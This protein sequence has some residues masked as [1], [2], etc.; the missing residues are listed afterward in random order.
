MAEHRGDI[1]DIAVVGPVFQELQGVL[2]KMPWCSLL[3]VAT[4][5]PPHWLEVEDEWSG[6][7]WEM[8]C[9]MP[10]VRSSAVVEPPEA[11]HLAF[12]ARLSFA[13]CI[14]IIGEGSSANTCGGGPRAASA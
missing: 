10:E 4:A 9:G 2:E 6:F 7:H 12:A 5:V 8:R 3:V 11:L 13:R 1:G 14:S